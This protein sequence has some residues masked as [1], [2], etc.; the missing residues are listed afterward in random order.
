[1][2]NVK[3]LSKDKPF[4][5]KLFVYGAAGSGKT[6][7]A[8]SIVEAGF[9]PIVIDMDGGASTLDGSDID[10]TVQRRLNDL[11]KVLWL[12]ASKSQEIAKYDAI[13]IDGFTEGARRELA[14]ITAL[15][16]KQAEGSKKERDRDVAQLADHGLKNNRI[17]RLVRMI[18]DLPDILVIVTGHSKLTYPQL[19]DSKGNLVDNKEARPTEIAPDVPDSLKEVVAGAFD[20]VWLFSFNKEKG[21]RELY[22]NGFE[23]VVAKTRNKNFANLL[24]TTTADGKTFPILVN[25]DMK[26]IVDAYK[27]AMQT[28]NKEGK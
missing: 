5:Q 10:A 22:T 11:E 18:R 21:R 2:L 15:A 27:Q 14:E 16:A 28:S 13:I 23:N 8:A 7:F 24:T 4:T 20:S 17:T 26:F 6:T 25:P 1:M 19:P 3:K 12:F 9:T